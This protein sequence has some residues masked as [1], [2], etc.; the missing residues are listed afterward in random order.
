M[1]SIRWSVPRALM[2]TS[3]RPLVRRTL[4]F[5]TAVAIVATIV[6]AGNGL[7]ARDLTR[8]FH[9]GPGA[10][11]ALALA[12]TV[13]AT[14]VVSGAFD[15]PGTRTLRTLPV[16]RGAWTG[17]LL[18]LLLLVQAPCGILFARADGAT[19]AMAESL[20]AVSIQAGLV[21]ATRRLRFA[22]LASAALGLV[23]VDARP[24]GVLAP[25]AVLAFLAVSAAW[26]L[27]LD[28]TGRDVRM[29]RVTTPSLALAIAHLLR[30]ARVSRA[31]LALAAGSVAVGAA[32]LVLSLENDPPARPVPRALAVLA[33][34]LTLCAA[35]MVDPVRET[36]ERIRALARVTRTRWTTL[37]FA[38]A[39][40]LVLPSSALAATAGA[41]AGAVTHVPALPLGGAAS[42][43]AIPIA[44]TIAAWARFHDRRTRRS[45]TLFVVGVVVVAA[46]ATGAGVAW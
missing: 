31:R 5:W 24:L 30:L 16:A 46:L 11:A 33:V 3:G 22:L 8:L 9:G 32:A 7:D 40:A 13:L 14:P 21:A 34:P 35:V 25:A 41:V 19:T 28:A 2:A 36:E 6:F 15:A 38:F 42:A 45:P 39:L 20:L 23:L 27:A 29:T 18:V 10:R 17:W 4:A 12:W 43:W 37:L 1:T 26:R 44:A